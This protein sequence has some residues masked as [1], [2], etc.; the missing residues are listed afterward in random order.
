M[1]KL[2]IDNREVEVP[3][4]ATVLDAAKKLG[5]DVPTMCYLKGFEPSTSCMVCR[6]TATFFGVKLERAE[7]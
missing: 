6:M 2:T 3:N 5:I 7:G 4:G 1:P